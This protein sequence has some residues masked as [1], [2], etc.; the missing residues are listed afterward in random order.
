MPVLS[1]FIC[2]FRRL[3]ADKAHFYSLSSVVTLKLGQ[4]HQNLIKSLNYTNVTI[5]EVWPESVIWF[6]RYDADKRFWSKFENFSFYSVVTLKIRSRSPKS[7]QIFQLSQRYN[8]WNLARIRH[9]VQEIGY[10]QAFF[11]HNLKNSKY[12]CDLENEV[13]VTKSNH[14]FPPS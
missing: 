14:I 13:K 1:K 2:W 12:W 8:I 11:G 6:K 10:K 9:L 5:H 7:N 3:S 4:D